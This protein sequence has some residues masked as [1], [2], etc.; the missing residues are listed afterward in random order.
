MVDWLL[1]WCLAFARG[2]QAIRST[3]LSGLMPGI[4]LRY[5]PLIP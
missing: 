3:R 1:A 2:W 5:F 4:T